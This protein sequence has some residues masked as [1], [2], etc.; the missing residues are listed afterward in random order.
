MVKQNKNHLNNLNFSRTTIV[1][2]L[3]GGLLLTMT[4]GGFLGDH[5]NDMTPKDFSAKVVKESHTH[6]HV[7]FSGHHHILADPRYL[8]ANNPAGAKLNRFRG[9]SD[10]WDIYLQEA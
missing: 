2:N 9:T 4:H 3:I 7:H 10:N 6:D 8:R 1:A 5:H